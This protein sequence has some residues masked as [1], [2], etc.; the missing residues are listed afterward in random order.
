M[1]RERLGDGS[2]GKLAVAGMVIGMVDF[3]LGIAVLRGAWRV[4][5]WVRTRE[6]R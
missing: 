1:K 4:G 3:G 5:C 6:E 2:E